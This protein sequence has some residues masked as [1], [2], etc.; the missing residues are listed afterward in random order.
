MM[1]LAIISLLVGMALG[2]RCNVLVLVPAIGLVL[3]ASM[4]TGFARAEGPWPSMLTVAS[5]I[6]GLQVGYLAG[7]GLASRMIPAKSV[8]GPMERAVH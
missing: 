6:T 5:M 1:M 3:L 7:I 8:E 4:A 2:Q